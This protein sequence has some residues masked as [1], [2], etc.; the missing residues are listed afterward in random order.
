LPLTS[1]NFETAMPVF[2]SYFYHE[3]I[4]GLLTQNAFFQKLWQYLLS[5]TATA[6]SSSNAA[7]AE[8]STIS[9]ATTLYGHSL[10]PMHSAAA[11]KYNILDVEGNLLCVLLNF[12]SILT[13]RHRLYPNPS[14]S[15]LS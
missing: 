6:D 12:D 1:S 11:T 13:H 15:T 9:A 3:D 7:A 8:P 5:T 2:Y 10:G 4:Q 14:T